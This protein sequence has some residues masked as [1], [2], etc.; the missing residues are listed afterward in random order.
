M[1]ITASVSWLI[2]FTSGDLELSEKGKVFNASNSAGSRD[3][4]TRPQA[5]YPYHLRKFDLYG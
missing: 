4:L 3:L 1:K 2:L 5:T